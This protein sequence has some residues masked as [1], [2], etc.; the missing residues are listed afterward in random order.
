ML[1]FILPILGVLLLQS[2]VQALELS[3]VSPR[4]AEPGTTVVVTGGPFT[5]QTIIYFGSEQLAPSEFSEK[6]LVFSVPALSPGSYDLHV[7]GVRKNTEHDYNFEILEPTPQIFSISPRNIDSCFDAANKNIS[8]QG[9]GITAQTA[10][11]LNGISVAK[12]FDAPDRLEF[13]LRPGM[14]AGVYGVKLKNPSGATSIPS[15]I[16]ISDQPK[17]FSVERGEDFVNHYEVIV[18]GNNFFF[19]SILT[20]SQ[21]DNSLS[22]VRHRPLVLHTHETNPGYLQSQISPLSDRMTYRDCQTLIYYRYPIDYQDKDL[23][24]Q[25]INPDGKKTQPF[26]ISLP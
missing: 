16:W 2:P 25:V 20:V 22:S 19:N 11:L 3:S 12:V 13:S 14:Q 9:K 5:N 6:R 10:V 7:G 18:R 1:K 21:S 24:L 4:M 8:I 17:I 26:N 15:S 23:Q